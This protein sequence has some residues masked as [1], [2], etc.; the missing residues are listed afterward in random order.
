[1][2]HYDRT[3]RE[4]DKAVIQFLY[5]ED[6]LDVGKTTF[7]KPKQFD[8]I[9]ENWQGFIGCVHRQKVE[10]GL[11]E[12]PR[13]A[14]KHFKKIDKWN[15][16]NPSQNGAVKMYRSPFTTWCQ[17]KEETL[18]DVPASL[19]DTDRNRR[20]LELA[21]QWFDLNEDE[22]KRY[23]GKA[24]GRCPDPVDAVIPAKNL[25]CLPEKLLGEIR[26]SE[27]EMKRKEFKEIMF[28][29][30]MQAYAAPGECVGLLAA[31]SIGEPSTQM[32]LNTFH[33]AGRGEM[34][35]TLGIPRLR[36]ILMTASRNISTPAATVPFRQ[37]V[38]GEEAEEVRRRLDRVFLSSVL[39]RFRLTDMITIRGST[40]HRTYTLILEV[41]LPQER[42]K[43]F[44]HL[45]RREI[46]RALEGGFYKSLAASIKKK[47]D[48][49]REA[50]EMQQERRR[51]NLMTD[52]PMDINTEGRNPEDNAESSD[53][54]ADGGDGD[55]A[56]AKLRQRHDD[57]AE[58]EGEEEEET[59]VAPAIEPEDIF[60]SSGE[61][62]EGDAGEVD[63]AG[64]ENDGAVP[65]GGGVR[66]KMDPTRVSK[67]LK[68]SILI[69]D[70]KYDPKKEK[71]AS[72]SLELP[73]ARS[74]LDVATLVRNEIKKFVVHSVSGIEKTMLKQEGAQYV[75]TT[76]GINLQAL[77]M[78]ADKLHVD[79][80]SANNIHTV[81]ETYGIEAAAKLIRKEVSMVFGCYGI[82]VDPRHLSLV[83][84]YM[85]QT[86]AYKPF[87]RKHM[88]T[89]SSPLLKMTFESTTNAMRNALIFG[90]KDHMQGPSA[91]IVL[92]QTCR[93]GSNCF[94]L[95]VPLRDMVKIEEEVMKIK[96]ETTD[97]LEQKLKKE[98]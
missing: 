41:S 94:D 79:K 88:E 50:M 52:E 59:E 26:K 45:S 93:V 4:S 78:Q 95:V 36:E 29:K 43:E 98:P 86:G 10:V 56:T 16:R 22:K 35:V 75:L 90:Q 63:Q 96:K 15:S 65:Q 23:L 64:G 72:V 66:K 83:A 34:N 46:L 85:T 42:D 97:F 38:T 27:K 24:D 17:D 70:Y 21:A 14:E 51:R 81:A 76:Q 60:S 82:E 57:G 5:G 68:Q 62:D 71:W 32:T 39:R 30:G 53:D 12:G 58:Y 48:D 13:K 69:H 25:G 89:S 37:G 40:R 33:F 55:A 11:V 44:Q 28:W 9:H 54:E 49:I 20:R 87:N 31:Q 7:L 47:H 2:V 3:V 73:L 67:V 61:E 84:D 8:F 74:K 77:F 18:I 91:N 1:M 19:N 92:G 6:G 80:I